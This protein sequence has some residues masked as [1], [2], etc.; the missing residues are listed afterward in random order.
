MQRRVRRL[1]AVLSR[2]Q[3]R[4]L[5]KDDRRPARVPANYGRRHVGLTWGAC[6]CVCAIGDVRAAPY[7]GSQLD[8][9]QVMQVT[10]RAH[11][12]KESW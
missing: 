1:D 12:E 6:V 5:P 4:R 10:R 11:I 8:L 3:V 9:P 2:V 7:L